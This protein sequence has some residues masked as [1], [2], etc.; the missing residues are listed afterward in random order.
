MTPKPASRSDICLS[1]DPLAQ[2]QDAARLIVLGNEVYERHERRVLER[3]PA[4]R[5]NGST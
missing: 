1:C 5:R 3:R 4:D 2:E